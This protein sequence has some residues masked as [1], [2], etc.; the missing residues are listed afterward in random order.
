MASRSQRVE[1]ARVKLWEKNVGAVAWDSERHVARFEYERSFLQSGLAI[2]P[3]MMPL[4]SGIFSFPTLNYD[5]FLGLPGLLSDALPDKF[6][7]A[8]IDQ[9]LLRQGRSI[10]DFSSIERLC[11]MGSRGIGA[12]EFEPALERGKKKSFPL[13]VSELVS[14]SQN[15]LRNRNNLY[16]T[17]NKNEKAAL[18]TIIQVGTSAGGARAKAVIAWNPK[19]D[20]V[21]SGQVKAPPGFE[22]WLLK[23]DGVTDDTLGDPFGF[24]RV[25]YAYHL[26]AAAA[27]IKMN[28]CRLLEENERSHFMVK[29]FDRDQG[30]AK[31]HMQSLCAMG[32]LDYNM[33]GA[34]GYE[35]A[36]DIIQR[37]NLGH[38]AMMEQFRRMV[39]NIV[40]RNQDDHT[41]N[42][43]FLMDA[44][45]A[46]SLSPAYDLT[47][48]YNP[49][50]MW[51]NKHQMQVNGKRDDFTKEDLLVGASRYNI[52]KGAHI[53]EEVGKAVSCWADFAETARV[54][55]S[56]IQ[57]IKKTHRLYLA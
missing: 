51:T 53:M 30:G 11:Y 6:G 43:S 45:G 52:K 50:G 56:M 2:S 29:R 28:Q 41:K 54:E 39:F 27:G 23:F 57:Q 8:L 31:I 48:S 35:H 40:A 55:R 33:P 10:S 37:L 25:E 9:W 36:F 44:D 16:V 18:N 21:R 46:W 42:I 3:I 12:L 20:E 4:G 49:K 26:M 47:W 5:T 38:Q 1:V 15:I 13:D 17:V 22:Y 19:T 24:G 14:L 7:N 32:H 34:Y